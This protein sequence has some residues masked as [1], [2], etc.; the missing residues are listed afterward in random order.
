LNLFHLFGFAELN[1]TFEL[2]MI[3]SWKKEDGELTAVYRAEERIIRVP[4]IERG[5]GV[6]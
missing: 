4:K 1:I 2:D 5:G 6:V 3:F